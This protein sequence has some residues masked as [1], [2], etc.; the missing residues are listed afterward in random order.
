MSAG[1]ERANPK[2]RPTWILFWLPALAV[3]WVGYSVFTHM[4]HEWA[5]HRAFSRIALGAP[6]SDAERVVGVAPTC[7]FTLDRREIL[8]F[9]P[10]NRTGWAQEV[11]CSGQP[12]TVARP[13]ELPWP[14]YVTIF[15]VLTP[16]GRIEGRMLSGESSLESPPGESLGALKRWTRGTSWTKDAGE[17][18]GVY[19]EPR[20]SDSAPSE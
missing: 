1:D 17:Q 10:G 20:A 6:A 7:R 12:R 8:Y 11:G 16:S 13:S 3:V 9:V 5:V 2:S 4:R 18:I 14:P 15:V 19:P